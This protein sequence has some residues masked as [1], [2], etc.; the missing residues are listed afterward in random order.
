MP[1][2]PLRIA[3]ITAFIIILLAV[4]LITLCEKRKDA[5]VVTTSLDKEFQL[6]IGEKVLIREADIS[7]F[8]VRVVEDTR[9]P[10]NVYCFWAG[11]VT[12]ELEFI[13]KNTPIGR[14]NLTIPVEDVKE[15][16]GYVVE[17]LRVEPQREYPDKMEIPPSEYEIT[18][19]VSKY[20]L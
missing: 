12:V 19:K 18:L 10:V 8:F 13:D 17:L 9:C 5:A 3:L 7:L 16:R 14:F 2:K 4:S 6:R 1:K 20:R 11:R 15:F